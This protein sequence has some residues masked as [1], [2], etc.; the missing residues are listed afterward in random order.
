MRAGWLAAQIASA[1]AVDHQ[2][3]VERRLRTSRRRPGGRSRAAA[4]LRRLSRTP[5]A[6]SAD[7]G[8]RP[9]ES[10]AAGVVA[11]ADAVD[12][13]REVRARDRSELGSKPLRVGDRRGEPEAT[14]GVP[15]RRLWPESSTST[16]PPDAFPGCRSAGCTSRPTTIRRLPSTASWAFACITAAATTNREAGHDSERRRDQA[17][18]SFD[19]PESLRSG[20]R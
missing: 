13:A 17:S 6:P 5:R 10:F 11:G 2:T 1:Q 7:R 4:C 14:R 16:H 3:A 15:S 8:R 19:Q 20:H 9:G 12:P 18:P